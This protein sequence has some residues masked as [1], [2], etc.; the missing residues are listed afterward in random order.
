MMVSWVFGIHKVALTVNGP[1]HWIQPLQQVWSAW[2]PD[3]DSEPW[4]ITLTESPSLSAPTAPLFEALPKCRAGVC[5]L[6]ASGF[7][8]QVDANQQTAQL[9]AHPDATPSDIGYFIRV[10]LAAQAFARGGLLFHAAGI[11][12]RQ[13]GYA[14]FGISG[15]GKTTAAHFSVP[16]PV[17]NDDLLLL[18]P[19]EH[20][21]QLYAT[22]FG[23]RR[24]TL[25]FA[26]LGG[27]FCLMKSTDVYVELLAPGRAL[28]E[29]VANTP[30]LCSDPVYLPHVMTRWEQII[31]EIPVYALY[32]RRDATFWEAIDAELG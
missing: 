21:W 23:K 16:D 6:R 27:F 15:S 1:G 13:Q 10:A 22:P 28:A 32:F 20:G 8:G 30:V 3:T 19:D 14:L 9:I 17:L 18:W 24:G 25:R 29:L 7:Q 5:K 4:P 12:H 31:T 26:P 2:L 11:V